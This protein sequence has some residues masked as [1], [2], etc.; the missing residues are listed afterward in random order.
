MLRPVEIIDH[1]DAHVN[2]EKEGFDHCT[3]VLVHAED[4]E[5]AKE[6]AGMLHEE[7][8]VSADV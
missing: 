5:E 4:E 1:H 3:N 6:I 2:E 7:F 8:G